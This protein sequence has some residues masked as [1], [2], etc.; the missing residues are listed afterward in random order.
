MSLVNELKTELLTADTAYLQSMTRIRDLGPEIARL[1][2][3][4]KE[5]D[6]LR[7]RIDA[8]EAKHNALASEAK[9]LGT[10]LTEMKVQEGALNDRLQLARSAFQRIEPEFKELQLTLRRQKRAIKGETSK[11]QRASDSAT[12][13]ERDTVQGKAKRLGMQKRLVQEAEMLRLQ[14]ALR[15]ADLHELGGMIRVARE[16]ATQREEMGA[17]LA[18]AQKAL[19]EVRAKV[20]AMSD[21]LDRVDAE[22]IAVEHAASEREASDAADAAG[23]D[24]LQRE[25]D[26]ARALMLKTRSRFDAQVEEHREVQRDAA[27]L[28]ARRPQLRVALA[29]TKAELDH[30]LGMRLREKERNWHRSALKAARRAD[31]R[32]AAGDAAATSAVRNEVVGL[33]LAKHTAA[34]ASWSETPS[35]FLR[36][37][38]S[39]TLRPAPYTHVHAKR[40][41]AAEKHRDAL[42]EE[43]GRLKQRRAGEFLFTVIFYA[44]HA[45]NLTRSP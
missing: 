30:V 36:D 15:L 17:R 1:T 35:D 27:R 11:F 10:E 3:S 8:D 16:A 45:H 12:R 13:Y 26:D 7:G 39:L 34:S 5:V 28:A 44:I 20:S 32:D 42:R 25:C 21:A 41:S 23:L 38:H 29:T 40:K 31:E 43:I 2:E 18:G 14:R 33:G 24:R 9:G 22:A 19:A 6:E 37:G 4:C